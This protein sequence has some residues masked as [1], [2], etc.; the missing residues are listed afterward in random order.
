LEVGEALFIEELQH[1]QQETIEKSR[2]GIY[3]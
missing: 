3:F 1:T 2:L